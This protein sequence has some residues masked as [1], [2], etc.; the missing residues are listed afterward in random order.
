MADD[1]N[2]SDGGASIFQHMSFILFLTKKK[3]QRGRLLEI[4]IVIIFGK[5]VLHVLVI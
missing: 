4:F 5:I 2:N 1:F 3:G